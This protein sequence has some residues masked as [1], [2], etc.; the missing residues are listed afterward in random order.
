MPTI[1]LPVIK[2]K[3]VVFPR[4]P[5]C[6]WCGEQKV[7]EPHSIAIINGGAMQPCGGDSY[8]MATETVA[9]LIDKTGKRHTI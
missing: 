2:E 4:E 3:Q 8:T 9:F 6:P 7:Y 5:L 1:E